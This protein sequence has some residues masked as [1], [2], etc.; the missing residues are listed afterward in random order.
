MPSFKCCKDCKDRRIEPTNCH[1]DCPKYLEAK[2]FVDERNAKRREG[3]RM[4]N[5]FSG[6]RANRKNMIHSQ[7]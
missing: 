2:A 7:I 5:E 4:V 6:L 3:M 1:T